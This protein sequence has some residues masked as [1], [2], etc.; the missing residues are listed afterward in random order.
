MEK[1]VKN[2]ISKLS[3][4]IEL[5]DKEKMKIFNYFHY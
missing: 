2:I 5:N 1:E 3:R 4:G